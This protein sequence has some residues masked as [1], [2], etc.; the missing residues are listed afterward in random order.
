MKNK[1]GMSMTIVI[2]II[3]SLLLTACDINEVRSA[4]QNGSFYIDAYG[5][6]SGYTTINGQF[7]I[8]RSLRT[9]SGSYTYTV[10]A[11]TKFEVDA[12]V[13][14]VISSGGNFVTW[15]ALP[16]EFQAFAM[17]T[18]STLP[19]F[20]MPMTPLEEMPWKTQKIKG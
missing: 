11:A 9:L 16:V 6:I 18:I 7:F 1:F 13:K 5:N 2:V 19:M 20:I 14:G 17:S 8:G 15:S 4:V 3:M 10:G 12:L